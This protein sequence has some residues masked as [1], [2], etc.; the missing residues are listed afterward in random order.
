MRTSCVKRPEIRDL[1]RLLSRI[2][3]Y[4]KVAR[5]NWRIVLFVTPKKATHQL[6]R[7]VESASAGSAPVL[8]DAAGAAAGFLTAGFVPA[9][10]LTG[11]CSR[12]G[13]PYRAP[14]TR[15]AGK[16]FRETRPNP[17][18]GGSKASR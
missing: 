5:I 12:G 18:R 7:D 11:A 14:T 13:S 8:T 10:R 17:S 3:A 6:T 2:R 15:A 1:A 16:I 9:I 4:L